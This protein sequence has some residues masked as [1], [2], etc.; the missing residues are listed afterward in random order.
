MFSCQAMVILLG[1]FSLVISNHG[2]FI[3]KRFSEQ[4]AS[5]QLENQP[6]RSREIKSF[7]R[8]IKR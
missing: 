7:A 2:N 4:P 8:M 5:F 1:I 3:W 6:K